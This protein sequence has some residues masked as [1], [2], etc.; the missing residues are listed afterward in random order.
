MFQENDLLKPSTPKIQDIPAFCITLERRQDR[1]KRFQDQPGLRAA[2]GLKKGIDVTRFVGVD[3]K[4][5][6][7]T[8]DN[9]IALSTK[10]NI[11]KKYRRSHEEL[12]SVGGVGCALSHIAIWQW[13]ID[14]NKEQ[15]LI[16][17]DDAQIPDDFI[18]RAN[19][20]LK[21]SPLLQDPKKWDMWL[22]GGKWA[23]L[24]YIPGEPKAIRIGAFYLFH[25]YIITLHGAKQLLQEVYPI[26]NHIDLWVS[27]Y[28]NVH[29]FRMV[30][31]KELIVQ[32][33][34]RVKTDI[35][36]EKGCDICDVPNNYEKSHTL[37]SKT[38]WKVAQVA[39]ILCVG[40]IGYI[41]YNKL[42]KKN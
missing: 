24:T 40:L 28:A 32:Q 27:I 5:I 38:E 12:D 23:D 25:A 21:E 37:I 33:C 15:V 20:C 2:N 39:E 8:T 1:W 35:Q 29:D 14:N 3:G 34:N 11:L 19:Q 9:R 41:L 42:I 6:D 22:L 4:T 31:C 16:F 17:E 10:R 26:Q 18:E 13:M 7:I 30:G 36:S